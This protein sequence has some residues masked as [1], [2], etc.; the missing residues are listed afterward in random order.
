VDTPI[1]TTVQLF[2]GD[3]AREAY[4]DIALIR[5]AWTTASTALMRHLDGLVDA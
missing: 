5:S 3:A 1:A 4:P 2:A